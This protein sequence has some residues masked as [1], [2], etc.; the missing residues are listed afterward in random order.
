MESL[1]GLAPFALLLLLC[2]LL[3]F[4]FM[5]GMHGGQDAHDAPKRRNGHGAIDRYAAD[6]VPAERLQEM[7]QELAALRRE[8]DATK[9]ARDAE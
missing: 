2:P 1:I 7:E 9:Q 5:R 4:V 6:P 3:M 8:L